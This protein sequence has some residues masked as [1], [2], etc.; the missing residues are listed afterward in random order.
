VTTTDTEALDG[1][2]LSIYSYL[3]KEGKPVGPREVMRATNLSSPSVAYWHLQKLESIGLVQ[4][5]SYGEYT[6]K[7]KVG[8][9]GHLWIG[10]KLVPRLICYSLFFLGVVATELLLICSQ[11]F[12]QGKVPNIDLFYLVVSNSIALALF[13]GE[14]LLIRKKNKAAQRKPQDPPQK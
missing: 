3:V 4:K 2:T 6:I 12:L 10:N 5:N 14:G 9:S 11:F 13:L 8:V 7:E 1:K